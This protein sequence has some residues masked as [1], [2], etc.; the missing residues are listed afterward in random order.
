MMGNKAWQRHGCYRL[1]SDQYFNMQLQDSALGCS[2]DWNSLDHFDPTTDSRRLFK[3][4][5]DLRSS[6]QKLQDGFGVNQ[7]GNWTYYITLPGSNNTATEMGLWAASRTGMTGQNLSL[8]SP[9]VMLLWMNDNSTKTYPINCKDTTSYLQTPWVTGTVIQNLFYPFEQITLIDGAQ[10]FAGSGPMRGCVS[11]FT[12][13][14]Y[15]FKAFVPAS[16]WTAPTPAITGFKPGHDARIYAEAGDANANNVD[17]T[18]EFNTVMDCDSVTS[19]ISLNMSSSG[20]GGSPTL[21]DHKC[22]NITAYTNSTIT[23]VDWS[24]W[25]WSTTLTNVPDGVLTITVNNPQNSGKTASTGV[26]F[27][28]SCFTIMN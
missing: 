14:P 6:Y 16:N 18:L 3:R 25:S 8:S 2:D 26:R 15:G 10:P 11:N 9:D 21:G 12:F 19:A 22:Q 7:I 17:I 5:I 1:G 4:F 13:S 23:G 24:V 27:P 20:H 28:S